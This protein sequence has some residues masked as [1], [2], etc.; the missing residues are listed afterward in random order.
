MASLAWALEE[1]T[2]F[3]YSRLAEMRY[4]TDEADLFMK[5]IQAEENHKQ[6]LNSIHC[7]LSEEPVERYHREQTET[8]L[9][10]GALLEEALVWAED[11]P[12]RRVLAAAMG[13]ET[14]AYDRY[15]KMADVSSDVTTKE[16][17]LVIA[18]EEKGHLKRLGELLDKQIE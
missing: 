13:F 7:G 17:F 3:L 9:E 2:R 18:K 1:N 8:F 11:K 16:M 12:A 5:L 4:G 15:I 6:M 10:G 14:N